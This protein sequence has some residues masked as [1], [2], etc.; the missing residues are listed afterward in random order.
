[1]SIKDL[2]EL[3]ELIFGIL[4]AFGI[5]FAFTLFYK[6]EKIYYELKEIRKEN[7]EQ[8]EIIKLVKK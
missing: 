1:M 4:M 6:L 3:I 5:G 7:S 2:K 8:E